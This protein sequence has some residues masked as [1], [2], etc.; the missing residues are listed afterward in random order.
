MENGF[1]RIEIR[2]REPVSRWEELV[3]EAHVNKL[4]M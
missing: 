1:A 2:R 3:N 4:K